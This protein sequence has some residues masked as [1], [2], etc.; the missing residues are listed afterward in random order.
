METDLANPNKPT[1]NVKA[2]PTAGRL[3][4]DEAAIE[5]MFGLDIEGGDTLRLIPCL[6]SQW[7]G[8]ELTLRRE[9]RAMHLTTRRAPTP[10]AAAPYRRRVRAR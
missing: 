10:P 4:L 5:S 8:A 3:V 1:D 7:P 6:P 2:L 9:G